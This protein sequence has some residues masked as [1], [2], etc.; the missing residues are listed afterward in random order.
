M[1]KKINSR[2]KLCRI[3]LIDVTRVWRNKIHALNFDVILFQVTVKVLQ[4][5]YFLFHVLGII[6]I[7]KQTALDFI[8]F[9]IEKNIQLRNSSDNNDTIGYSNLVNR[10]EEL[11]CA[12]KISFLSKCQPF[13]IRPNEIQAH[14]QM[15]FFAQMKWPAIRP[16]EKQ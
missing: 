1:R 2:S 13:L 10:P 9:N 14:T 16:N 15:I 6:F 5:F 3:P 11:R 12:G 7:I 4:R 8:F